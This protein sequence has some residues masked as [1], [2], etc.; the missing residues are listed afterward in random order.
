MD[1]C[2]AKPTDLEHK[3]EQIE[4]KK[5]SGNLSI[6]I[7][8]KTWEDDKFGMHD[9]E[10]EDL[11]YSQQNNIDTT[12]H[13]CRDENDEISLSGTKKLFKIEQDPNGT[14]YIVPMTTNPLWRKQGD[15]EEGKR[16]AA[17]EEPLF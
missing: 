12:G 11:I 15:S 10:C 7:K 13:I 5:L 4:V 16:I 1:N 3:S 9:Y 14:V 17:A 2:F 8:M 6:D